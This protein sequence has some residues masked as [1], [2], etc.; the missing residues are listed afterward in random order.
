M[1]SLGNSFSWH[2]FLYLHLTFTSYHVS[3]WKELVSMGTKL[4]GAEAAE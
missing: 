2:D 4:A 3:D 1:Q